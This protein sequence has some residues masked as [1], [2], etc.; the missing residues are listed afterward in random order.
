LE[1]ATKTTSS[2]N[3]TTQS[4]LPVHLHHRPSDRCTASADGGL[5][6][7][8]PGSTTRMVSSGANELLF[9]IRMG[10]LLRRVGD[11]MSKPAAATV[12]RGQM[13][14]V[15]PGRLVCAREP[16][17]HALCSRRAL[18]REAQAESAA[19]R[20]AWWR[21]WLRLATVEGS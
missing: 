14:R 10:T 16:V 12:E 4:M 1:I 11:G 17:A 7:L 9:R 3:T 21:Q 18:E 5:L 19:R 6:K 20:Q 15:R 2:T 8:P 13:V